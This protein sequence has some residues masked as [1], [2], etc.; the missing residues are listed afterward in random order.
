MLHKGTLRSEN[1]SIRQK[2]LV[3]ANTLVYFDWEK[4]FITVTPENHSSVGV[5]LTTWATR[6]GETERERKKI[7]TVRKKNKE[8]ERERER[9]MIKSGRNKNRERDRD[10][11]KIKSERRKEKREIDREGKSGRKNE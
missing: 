1:V 9:E 3:A 6:K 4:S 11:K 2:C 8:R 5:G 10:S 7:K